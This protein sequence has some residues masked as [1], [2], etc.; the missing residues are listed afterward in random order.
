METRSIESMSLVELCQWRDEITK[1][2]ASIESQLLKARMLAASKRDFADVN[3]FAKANHALKMK[4]RDHQMVLMEI[5]RRNRLERA[6]VTESR[7]KILI[8]LMRQ[9]M[10]DERFYDL[11]AQADLEFARRSLEQRHVA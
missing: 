4:K 10:P 9:T 5:A 3:W 2:L 1:D 11:C 7:D 6:N 8:K